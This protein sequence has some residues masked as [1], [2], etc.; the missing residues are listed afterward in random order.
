[1]QFYGFEVL[2]TE[3]NFMSYTQRGFGLKATHGFQTTAYKSEKGWMIH[4]ASEP[5]T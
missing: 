3:R 1:M 4:Y 2:V 5:V